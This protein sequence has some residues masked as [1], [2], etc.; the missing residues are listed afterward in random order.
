LPNS[1]AYLALMLWPIVVVVLFAR[2]RPDRAFIW[3]ILGGYLLLPPIAAFGMPLIPDLDKFV[4]PALSVLFVATLMKGHRIAILPRSTLARL[5]VLLLVLSP[6]ATALTNP[7]TQ[8]VVPALPSAAGAVPAIRTLQPLVPWDGLSMMVAQCFALLPFLLARHFLATP[9]AARELVRALVLAGLGYS[10]LMLFEVR[11]SPQLNIWIYGFFQHAFEQMIRGGGF[12]PIV[13]LEHGLWVSLFC[14][15]AVLAAAGLGRFEPARRAQWRLA[16]A[17][18]FGVLVLSR[19]LGTL[20]LAVL[21]VPL[22]FMAPPRLMLRLCGGVAAAVFV[23]PL[24]RAG[25][26]VPVDDIVAFFAMIDADRAASLAFRLAHEGLLLDHAMAK[27]WFGWGAWMRNLIL[28]PTTGELATIADG[29]WVIVFGIRGAV[30]F[31]AEFGLLALPLFAIALRPAGVPPGVAILAV[32]HAAGMVD[33]L[34]NGTLTPV[35]WLLVGA[36]LAH[37]ERPQD[38]PAAPAPAP[39]ATTPARPRTVL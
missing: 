29:R 6:W 20:V 22:L 34:P 12:R 21:F 9:E 7:E 3:S 18:L 36:L 28:D 8:I 38:A 1:I 16:A 39:A 15:M 14:M 37:V 23:Y 13:F 27:P 25:G 4:I 19:S 35:T 17:Y 2:L 24:L 30:G 10:L 11:M 26:A 5:L 33:L 32:V 31:V